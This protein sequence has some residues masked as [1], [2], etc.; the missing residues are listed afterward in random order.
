MNDYWRATALL[1]ATLAGLSSAGAAAQTQP[2]QPAPAADA[3]GDDS[4]FF[5]A[6]NEGGARI[7]RPDRGAC[8]R[9]Q[10]MS[11]HYADAISGKYQVPAYSLAIVGLRLPENEAG[12]LLVIDTPTGTRECQ[13]GSVMQT[14]GG[15]M[16]AHTYAQAKDGSVHYVAGACR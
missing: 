7:Y 13:L 1:V 2:R 5:W 12:C 10:G 14:F 11:A 6:V 15:S 9:I 8:A 4:L 16:L 3:T